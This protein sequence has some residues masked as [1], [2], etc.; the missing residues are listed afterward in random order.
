MKVGF[1][2]DLRNPLGRPWR[3]H[4]EDCLRLMCESEAMGFDYVMVQEH[5]FQPDGYAP[6][7]P[8]FLTLLAERTR[9]IRIGSYVY[10]LPL[11]HAAMLAQ[12]TAVLDHLS[13]GRLDV[14]VGSGHS[15]A[16]YRALGY[17]PKTR[18]SRMQEGIEVLKRA[19]TERPF[20]YTGRYYD[21]HDV[22]VRPAPLQQPHPPLWVAA[23]APPAARRAGQVGAHLHGAS[24]DPAFHEAYFAGLAEAGVPRDQVRI[25]N[26]WS[27]TVT[28]ESPDAVWDRRKDLIFERWDFYRRIRDDMGD[29]GLHYGLPPSPEAYRDFELIGDA[30]TVIG[31]LEGFVRSLPLTDI[32]HS[33]PAGGTPPDEAYADLKRFADQVLP[34]LKSW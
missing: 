17:S 18:P 19:W 10:I 6:S 22:V 1:T 16:E 9:T 29:Q 3:D 27:I 11:H 8:V 4:W 23:T 24:V 33:G 15:A 7:V 20:S 31:T 34:T 5:F 13:E 30:D 21:L 32:V 28:D 26:P 25:S 12:E 2:M 14:T